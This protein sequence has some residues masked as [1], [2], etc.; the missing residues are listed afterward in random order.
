MA[1]PVARLAGRA[2]LTGAHRISEAVRRPVARTAEDIPGDVRAVTAEWLGTV[3]GARIR[4]A[5][6]V[7]GS[8]AT[9]SR[10]ALRLT[11]EEDRPDLP[12]DV[13]VKLTA[14]YQQ[15]L[16]LGLIRILDGEPFFYDRVRPLLGDVE[17][18]H[19][20]HG[21][22]DDASWRSAVVIEDIAAT[23]GAEFLHATMS[24]NRED[25]ASLLTVL[26]RV[27]GT[28]WQHDVVLRSNLKRPAD[29]LHNLSA[30]LNMRKCCA[31]GIER[32]GA[33]FPAQLRPR[34]PE[35]WDGLHR[36]MQLASNPRHLTFLHGDTH[37]GNTY[38]TAGGRMGYVDWQVA[39]RGSWAYDVAYALSSALEP[40]DRREWER[41]L[42]THY[43]EQLQKAGGEAPEFEAAWTAYRQ[44]LM[45]PLHCW[46][47]VYG[48]A[49]W[50]PEMQP[51][52]ASRRIISRVAIA[53]DDLG[54]LETLAVAR[55]G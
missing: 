3:L 22:H 13:F 11:Y 9:T 52:D 39:M 17:V 29:H 21:A 51:E 23:R 34:E 12:R 19:G 32:M 14:S 42:L 10:V 26:A 38:R 5:T 25:M 20:F 30:F 53:I 37:V 1:A 31:R 55:G 49:R 43:L 40:D 16:F 2:V 33:D 8:S 50:M 45:Y 24:I 46:T 7:G 28:L 47:C 44:N 35:L 41:D 48:A 15:R 4:D 6:V 27:H 54:A 18:P 36:S